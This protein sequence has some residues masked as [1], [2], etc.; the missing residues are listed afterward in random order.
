MRSEPLIA[1]SIGPEHPT[2]NLPLR[3]ALSVALELQTKGQL[4]TADDVY[5]A[6]LTVVPD[7]FDALHLSGVLAQQR[8]DSQQAVRRIRRALELDP[9]SADAYVN[10]SVSL[11]ALGRFAQAEQAATSALANGPGLLQARRALAAAAWSQGHLQRAYEI[12]EGTLQDAP[13]HIE[14]LNSLAALGLQTGRLRLAQSWVDKALDRTSGSGRSPETGLC[15]GA[16]QLAQGD[17]EAALVTFDQ[18]AADLSG[19]AEWWY[20]RSMALEDVGR[21]DDALDAAERALEMRPD[22]GPTLSDVLFLR[23]RLCRWSGHEPLL[24][25]YRAALAA[26]VRGLKPFSFLC[27]PATLQE[28]KRCAELWA[29]QVLNRAKALDAGLQPDSPLAAE[30]DHKL[31]VGYL[32]NGFGRHPTAALCAEL[33]ERH[34]RSS[35]EIFGYAISADDGSQLRLRI[36]TAC[37]R[38]RD[39]SQMSLQAI[40]RQL[41]ADELDIL[42]DLRGYG[43]GGLPEVFALR[44]A[45]LQVQYFAFP[46]TMG[47][48]FIDYLIADPFVVQAAHRPGYAERI[49]QLPD[50]FQPNDTTRHLT[51][52]TPTKTECGLPENGLVLASFN[53]SYKFTRPVFDCWMKL[54]LAHPTAVLWLLAPPAGTS[55]PTTLKAAARRSGLD[56]DRIRF[57]PKLPHSAY[58]LRYQLVDL[59]L[60]TFPYNAH[61]TA[62]DALWAG[63]PVLTCAGETFASRVAGSLLSAAGLSELVTENLQDYE[64]KA[65]ALLGDP[66]A[67]KT[68]KGRVSAARESPLFDT[69][70]LVASLESAYRTMVEIHRAGEA[71]RDLVITAR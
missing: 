37:S 38:F 46:G 3:V 27:E 40:A 50:R 19:N 39:M 59:F 5:A 9:G 67:L 32:S 11:H 21:W 51:G 56:P 48:A 36:K 64:A 63:C 14:T 28:Q 41:Q 17:S 70:Q 25:R 20:Q 13:N 45:P 55:V 49:V 23:R 62:S 18:L 24:T 26:G 52:R 12:Y 6:I 22:H 30:Q 35:F 68:I 2:R 44:V 10:L 57:M 42:V 53:N 34:T 29:E 54:L 7:N 47:A 1:V 58:L 16:L 66:A 60:D 15:V 31:R 61:T 8:G 33:L 65:H 4:D 71:P 43:G 69:P